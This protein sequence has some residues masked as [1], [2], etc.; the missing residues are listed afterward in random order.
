VE[1]FLFLVVAALVVAVIVTWNKV[2]Q[3]SERLQQTQGQLR[4]IQTTLGR[5]LKE[6]SGEPSAS[7]HPAAPRA[8]APEA[9]PSPAPAFAGRPTVT[10]AA[11]STTTATTRPTVTFSGPVTPSR[12][13]A[14]WEA[15]VG[16]RLLS[17][18]GAVALVIGVGF[19]LKYAF[20]HQWIPP[21]LRVLMGAAAAAVLILGATSRRERY[22]ILAQALLG[23]GLGVGY[24][25]AYATFAFYDL[26]P[27]FAAILLMAAV[28]AIAFERAIRF[29]SL[30]VG[31]IGWLGGFLTPVLLARAGGEA[32][33]FFLY[34]IALDIGLLALV[35]MKPP[36]WILTPL[37]VG[38]SYISFFTW[39]E[40]SYGS[41]DFVVAFIALVAMW[42]LFLASDVDRMRRHD[43]TRDIVWR[44]SGTANAI[45]FLSGGLML[46]GEIH[47]NFSGLFAA[48]AGLAYLIPI[49]VLG[50]SRAR[51]TV[52][53]VVLIAI[54]IG[55]Q[56]DESLLR[57]ALWGAEGALAIAIGLR[58]RLRHLRYS[59]LALFP[60]AALALIGSADAWRFVPI[61]GFVP[62]AN[63]RALT[64]LALAL[65]AGVASFDYQD[66]DVKERRWAAPALHYLWTATLFGL[67][68]VEII[69][70]GRLVQLAQ[71]SQ[72]ATY[73]ASMALFASW[74]LF[75]ALLV[76][77]SR[78][79]AIPAI[80]HA[81]LSSFFLAV[82]GASTTGAEFFPPRDF[83]LLANYRFVS[84]V[85]VAA[86][87][88]LIGKFISEDAE[89]KP[90]ARMLVF[91]SAAVVLFVLV[92]GETRD[93]FQR[94][95]AIGFRPGD[96]TIDLQSRKQLALSGVWLAYSM[97]A[98]S[99]GIWRRSRGLRLIAITLFG[100]TVLK[101]F[102]YDLSFLAQLY[103]IFSFIGLGLILL[104]VSYLYQRYRSL[105]FGPNAESDTS[106]ERN[107]EEADSRIELP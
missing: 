49:Q 26:V 96:T 50:E 52:K 98:M 45:F 27:A 25:T 1:S 14:E 17:R 67:I 19:F 107:L 6:Q 18:I 103:R 76:W 7:T 101:V 105:I 37:T 22:P 20:D 8:E 68:T 63:V 71:G 12:T 33:S 59:G 85:I 42:M 74:A 57:V 89:W 84:L 60:V 95:I 91:G 88:Y 106:A 34:L 24:L 94:K 72:G 78:S 5:L 75:G 56:F 44:F 69:D 3:M 87:S 86:T 55:L 29:D 77:I 81:G 41:A 40:S 82:L 47:T 73:T 28:T 51:Y 83:V 21:V 4:I 39:Y 48:S 92:T 58:A 90:V 102:L 36:W 46:L 97:A 11:P 104:A 70:Y 62:L 100:V 79:Q 35:R 32:W 9:Q 54:A 30:A 10:F 53:A 93:F 65:T 13:R 66:D 99:L 64:F 61:S 80:A 16:E 23:A 2:T 43:D 31:F 15:L 38:A